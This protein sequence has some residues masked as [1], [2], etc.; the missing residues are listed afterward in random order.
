[1][2]LTIYT[3]LYSKKINRIIRAWYL[4]G[5]HTHYTLHTDTGNIFYDRYG[6]NVDLCLF[7]YLKHDKSSVKIHYLP[8][9]MLFSDIL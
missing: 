7:S 4:F 3:Y 5:Y 8:L 6:E 1:M 2:V 9:E